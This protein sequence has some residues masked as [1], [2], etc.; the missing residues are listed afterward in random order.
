MREVRK[1]FK[2][3][4]GGSCAHTHGLIPISLAEPMAI[5]EI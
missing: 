1:V 5:S 4:G 3:L 2:E